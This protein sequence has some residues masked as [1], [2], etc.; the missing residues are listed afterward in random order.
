[1]SN[2]TFHFF[3]IPKVYLKVYTPPPRANSIPPP[4]W[5]LHSTRQK[6]G[7][8]DHEASKFPIGQKLGPSLYQ[9]KEPKWRGRSEVTQYNHLGSLQQTFLGLC[10]AFLP[11]EPLLNRASLGRK[12][13]QSPMNVCMAG[14]HLPCK[15][16]LRTYYPNFQV[17]F[18]S[19]LFVF[20]ISRGNT[21]QLNIRERNKMKH[22][23]ISCNLLL[24]LG[25]ARTNFDP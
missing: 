9:S 19:Y 4:L 22:A 14:Y 10:H 18:V 6:E 21:A 13:W 8:L 16:K 25:W 11:Q 7:R 24:L 5:A 12:V 2:K 20:V 1:M 3:N 23:Y 17:Y 15:N